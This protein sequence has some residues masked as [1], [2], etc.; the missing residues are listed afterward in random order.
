MR[1][2]RAAILAL[3]LTVGVAGGVLQAA[4]AQDA[5]DPPTEGEQNM[6][7]LP[8]LG[9]YATAEQAADEIVTTV[10]PTDE[11]EA[12]DAFWT[13]DKMQSAQLLDLLVV[14]E[15]DQAGEALR[16]RTRVGP[17][18]SATGSLPDAETAE[19][20]QT[21]YPEEWARAASDATPELAMPDMMPDQVLE[22]NA[23]A[24]E[25][26]DAY[27][28]TPPFTSYYVNDNTATWKSYPWLTIGRLFFQIPGLTGTY[29]C[30]GAA[31]YGRAVW[32][33]GHCVYTT[34]R[35]WSYNMWF[36]PAYRNGAYPYG[37]FT[38]KSRTA[39]S[40][41]V[42]AG[43]LAYDIGMVTV[44]DK[45]GLKLS[46]WVGS[47]GVLWNQPATQMFHAFGYPGNYSSGQYL[48]AC[49]A[50]TYDRDPLAGPDAIGIGCNMGSGAS[51][52]PWLVAYAPFKGTASN[53]VNGIVSYSYAT[54][55]LQV[56]G[57]YFGDEAK[58]LYDWAKV[59]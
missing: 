45:D 8:V 12:A 46:Q 30:T 35:G 29:A 53:Y 1:I 58:Q 57:P 56:Y 4:L 6:L 5:P 27:A 25:E 44:N 33:A 48:V 36:V 54:K 9:V 15:G 50:S 49:A 34:G 17:K 11:Q 32:T 13:R 40:G 24:S 23:A 41:W 18:G 22:L 31:A 16:D 47:L 3:I 7:Y 19:L 28:A 43:N 21:L 42:S 37:S 39:L 10:V 26:T 38:V 14:K 55:P 51:G 2:H 59:Q 52:G 20:A